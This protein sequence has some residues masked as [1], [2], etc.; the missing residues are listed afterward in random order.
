MIT[1]DYYLLKPS[2]QSA[3]VNVYRTVI[4]AGVADYVV[5]KAGDEK[6]LKSGLF[7][8]FS[9][10][11]EYLGDCPAIAAKAKDPVRETVEKIAELYSNCSN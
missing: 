8:S 11:Y 1:G 5:R 10:L 3:K 2:F 4:P 7:T 9:K 6:G